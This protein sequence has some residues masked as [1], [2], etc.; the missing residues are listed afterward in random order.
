MKFFLA[1]IIT[2]LVIPFASEAQKGVGTYLG[3]ESELYA[4]TKQVNQFFRRFNS[5]EDIEGN[6]IY[7][8]S[9][10]FRNPK[11]RKKFIEILFDNETSS[12]DKALKSI[13]ITDVTDNTSPVFLDFHG[14][15]WFSE[16]RTKFKYKGKESSVILFMKLQEE[17]IG[18]KWV[19]DKVYFEPFTELLNTPGDENSKFLHPLSHELDFMNLNKIF[20]KS[21]EVA[22]F[23]RKDFKPDHLTLFL[24]EMKKGNLS[25]ITIKNVKF[26]F[27]QIDN[28]YFE[29]SEFNRKGYN[30][31]WLISNLSK[32]DADQ[33][34]SFKKYIY[35]ENE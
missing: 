23:T 27:F 30:T 2:V 3:D 6:R 31:G 16:V 4:S 19:I 21:D 20:S 18:S 11:Q 7:K 12:L 10:K 32:L 26:H 28:W 1:F 9:K 33:K 5:E 29:L 13:F 14:G 24:L 22:L 35:F 34:E 25:F 17:K 15:E 8:G